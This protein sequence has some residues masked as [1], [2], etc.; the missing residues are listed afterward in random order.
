LNESIDTSDFYV[1]MPTS[2]SDWNGYSVKV[3]DLVAELAGFEYEILWRGSQDDWSASS[4]TELAQKAV[5]TDTF[6][7]LGSFWIDN[8]E[9][10]S[11]GL[12][13]SHHFVDSSGVLMTKTGG[14]DS[15]IS[16]EKFLVIFKP[17]TYSVWLSILVLLFIQAT[18][19]W[20]LDLPKLQAK[21][22]ADPFADNKKKNNDSEQG[23]R[24]RLGREKGLRSGLD[25]LASIRPALFLN[26]QNY[27]PVSFQTSEQ[28]KKMFHVALEKSFGHFANTGQTLDAEDKKNKIQSIAWGVVVLVLV[29]AYTANLASFL[30]SSSSSSSSLTSLSVAA[31]NGYKICTEKGSVY[32]TW[33]STHYQDIEQVLTDSTSEIGEAVYSGECE[34]AF[35]GQMEAEIHLNNYCNALSLVGSTYFGYGGG[36]AM[37]PFA[38]GALML[39]AVDWALLNLDEAGYLDSAWEESLDEYLGSSCAT[40]GANSDEDADTDDSSDDEI[41]LGMEH[42]ASLFAFYITVALCTFLWRLFE[43]GGLVPAATTEFKMAVVQAK[44]SVTSKAKSLSPKNIQIAIH[45]TKDRLSSFASTI[46]NAEERKEEPSTSESWRRDNRAPQPSVNV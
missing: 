4:Y 40:D 42:M 8:S 31:S 25:R 37:K 3:L 24:S 15:D 33:L 21:K 22:Q 45:E 23:L 41:Q 44:E 14:E 39:A 11:A 35:L 43:D 9:R 2:R 17:F 20:Y 32:S 7:L 30:I 18:A 12:A 6:D 29:A 28:R 10:R 26:P 13:I 19:S 16:Y 46:S 34:G 5:L 1:G 38:C 27:E 36:F